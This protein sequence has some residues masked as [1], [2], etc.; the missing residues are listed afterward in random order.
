MKTTI[1]VEQFD[2]GCTIRSHT[3][4]AN[5]TPTKIVSLEHSIVSDIGRIVW[6]DIQAKMNISLTNIVRID[7]EYKAP[8]ESEYKT[9][10][11][12]NK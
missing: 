10:I 7:I 5:D 2:N 8:E 12:P 4:A 9:Q 11:K 6:E 3:D 1:I